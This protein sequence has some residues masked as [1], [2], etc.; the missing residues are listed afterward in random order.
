[1]CWLLKSPCLWD[2]P[3]E[4]ISSGM[5]SRPGWFKMVQAAGRLPAL[6]LIIPIQAPSGESAAEVRADLEAECLGMSWLFVTP[7]LW[8]RLRETISSRMPCRPGWFK[9]VQAAGRLPAL[10]L[11]IPGQA[12]SGE[13]AVEVCVDP[14][15]EVCADLEAECLG[16]S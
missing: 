13:S 15:V 12:P 6:A 1:M 10:P 16:S 7:C 14:A 5:P 4:T 11:F 2:R 8:D 9:M 3:P